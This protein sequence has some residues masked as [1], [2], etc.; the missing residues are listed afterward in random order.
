[1]LLSALRHYMGDW[2][3]SSTRFAEQVLRLRSDG[4]AW[5][6]IL[7]D[8]RGELELDSSIARASA[9]G[10]RPPDRRQTVVVVEDNF[11]EPRTY[12]GAFRLTN[13][14]N[15][16]VHQGYRVVFVSLKD[17][18]RAVLEEPLRHVTDLEPAGAWSVPQLVADLN[19]ASVVWVCRPE[20][21][22]RILSI[23]KTSNAINPP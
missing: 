14:M 11:P 21:S 3:L 19:G 20:A 13:A 9:D 18:K 5:R 10:Q 8:W 6:A 2:R 16:A 15:L 4:I 17:R 22:G 23:L 7:A 1:M 12:S